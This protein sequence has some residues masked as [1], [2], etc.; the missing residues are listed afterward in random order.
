[1]KNI[2]LFTILTFS[3]NCKAQEYPLTTDTDVPPNSYIKDLNNE[4]PPFEGVWKGVWK[5]KTFIINFKKIKFYNTYS[6]NKQY[7]QDLLIGKFQVKDTNGSILFDNLNITDDKSKIKGGKI[8]PGGNTYTLAYVDPD[9]CL[10]S[11]RI[12][13]KF[14]NIAKTEIKFKFMETS[15]LIEPDCFYHGKPADQRPEPLPKEIILT[16]Q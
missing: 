4:L 6:V 13:V 3:L 2:I 9:L 1:M 16:K 11:G 7:Y 15:D 12:I 10:K 5:G 8:F 14:N